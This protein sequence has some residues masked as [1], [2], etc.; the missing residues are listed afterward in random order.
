MLQ[1]D[2][3]IKNFQIRMEYILGL[4]FFLITL[5]IYKLY[6]LQICYAQK[7]S[8]MSDNNRIKLSI[9]QPKRG[10]IISADNKVLASSTYYYKLISEFNK[11]NVL[12][13]NLDIISAAISLS[14]DE[15]ARLLS[16]KKSLYSPFVLKEPLNW[17]EYVKI[18][19]QLFKLNDIVIECSFVREY[20]WPEEFSHVIG[21]VT[22]AEND[23]QLSKG[24]VGIEAFF[25]ETLRGELGHKQMEINALGKKIRLLKRH[26]A[27]NGGDLILTINAELQR[28][29]YDLLTPH[30]AGAGIV[31]DIKTGEILALVSVPG[32]DT[33]LFSKKISVE[34]WNEI[35]LNRLTPLLNRT[36]AAYPPGSVFKIVVA[37]AALNEK[38]ISPEDRIF[39][40][41]GTKLDNHIFHC[42]K[43]CGH[44]FVNFYQALANSCDCYFFELAY[45]LGID[46]IERYAKK[47]GFGAVTGIELSNES[48]G[49]MPSRKWKILKYH[50]TWKPYETFLVGIGQGSVLATLLQSVVMFGKIFSKSYDFAPTLIKGSSKNFERKE[51]LQVNVLKDALHQVCTQGTAAR[52][53]QAPYGIFGKTGSSQLR[54]I[55]KNEVG[56]SQDLLKREHRDHAFFVG[57]APYS[58]PKYVVGIFI[59]HG[60][61]GAKVAAPIARAVFDKVMEL[62]KREKKH[63][64]QKF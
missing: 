34:K 57:A 2:E 25:D 42:W 3:N 59:E 55:K 32:Y 27:I 62:E 44:G 19:L 18:S 45:K 28:Y 26:D 47:L 1:R 31:M 16:E 7:Y 48:A 14:E 24:I 63:E 40:S 15:K 52:S 12:K 38:V 17:N 43:R 41:G 46:T 51:F 58:N 22:K 50:S 9:L 49:I 33:N 21:Y 5:L 39:C 8:L 35:R 53:C 36:V 4:I 37:F 29:I 6:V 20:K 54:A 30:L 13:N 23:F 56:I 64:E 10:K 11:K 61:G 60:G